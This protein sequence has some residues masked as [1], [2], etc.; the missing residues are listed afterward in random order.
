MSDADSTEHTLW[1]QYSADGG[2]TWAILGT[3][4]AGTTLVVDFDDLPGSANN[5]LLRVLASDGVNTGEATSGLFTVTKTLPVAE[6]IFPSD[7]DEFK[8]GD[9]VWLQGR[10]FDA[11]DGTLADASIQWESNIDGILGNG[12]DLPLTSLV[13]GTHTISMIVTDGDGN[14]ATDTINIIVGAEIVLAADASVDLHQDS[15]DMATGVRLNLTRAFDLATGE[16]VSARLETFQARLTYNSSCINIL[17]IRGEDFTIDSFTIDDTTGV[18]TFS[19]S[20]T[21]GVDTLAIL[22][23]AVTRLAGSNTQA[24]SLLVEITNLTELGGTSVAVNPVT[25]EFRRGDARADGAINIADALFIAQNLVG[26]RP[27]CTDVVDT[28]CLHS[29]NAASV[30]HD[31]NFD[32]KTIADALFIAQHLVGLRNEFYNMVP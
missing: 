8:L 18:A 7:G 26:L 25:L 12:D 19:G 22:G 14:Q 30:R 21:S 28:N 23:F 9:L 16:N 11:D 1:V 15:A 27:A 13:R 31:G 17:E 5:S 2:A 29:V 10:G 3:A 20:S 6:I 24:C 4:L 32:K